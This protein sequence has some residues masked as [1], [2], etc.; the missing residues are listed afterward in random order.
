MTKKS[1]RSRK[2]SPAPAR[3]SSATGWM[4]D[5]S[6]LPAQGLTAAALGL[7]LLLMALIFDPTI[8]TGGDNGVYV[9]L[10]RALLERHDY[11]NLHDPSLSP[12][13]LYPPGYPVILALASL[14]GIRPWVPLKLLAVAFSAAAVGFTCLWL[15][16]RTSRGVALLT[17][18]LV[19]FSP[20]LL[21]QGHQ[22]LSDVPCWAFVMVALW[23]FESLPRADRGRIVLAALATAIAYLTRTATVPLVV[24]GLGWLA[25]ERR[26][27]QLAIF[28][29][30]VVP[31][32]AAWYWWTATRGA[33]DLTYGQYA[34][35]FWLKDH[36]QPELG[37]A[38]I[39]DLLMRPVDN[40]LRYAGV[41]I[42]L[43][44]TGRSGGLLILM[45]GGLIG[46][47]LIGWFRRLPSHGI[48]EFFFPFYAGM[49]AVLP[50]PWA[51]ER[52]LFPIFPIALA[53]A[54]EGGKWLAER[55]RA[56]A[57]PIV[58]VTAAAVLLVLGVSPLS[59]TMRYAQACRRAHQPSEPYA[60]LPLQWQGY[61]LMAEWTRSGLPEDAVVISRKPGLFYALS[62]RRGI[63]IPKTTDAE[64]FLRMA[65]EAGARYLVM[66][67]VDGLTAQYS[68]PVVMRYPQ[69]FCLARHGESRNSA[70][71]GIQF[72]V[73]R[74][75][76]PERGEEMTI[77]ECPQSFGTVSAAS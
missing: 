73:P 58:G 39:A 8:F 10:S 28:A 54:L 53:Y 69:S 5:L 21:R 1:K 37:R 40:G 74:S 32:V 38:S 66:D 20:G 12:H 75:A 55:W 3:G 34:S 42:P 19:A 29:A 30:F 44:L 18:V 70:L 36:Y 61:L 76:D 25:F 43:L 41:M 60:C 11:V 49:L 16:R 48:A 68:V 59:E 13:T 67:Q 33:A 57:V 50:T 23:A 4:P 65:E 64:E 62:D 15:L 56:E 7:H 22:E 52:Y 77:D 31:A 17:A 47:S 24:A 27:R 72:Q 9:A 45:G 71:L 35:V 46:L 2:D 26:W 6:R 63:D 51:G 14:V